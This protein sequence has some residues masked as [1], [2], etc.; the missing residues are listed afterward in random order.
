MTE[1]MCLLFVSGTVDKLMAGTII[2]SG[3][4][5][6]DME[7]DVFVSFWGLMEFR[8]GAP[9]NTKVSYEGK[10]M[11]A[12]I[13]QIMREKKVQ[14]WIEMLR[15]A[16]EVGNVKVYACAMFSD[17]L[18]LQKSDYDPI[19]DEIIGV[20]EFVSMAKDAKMTLFI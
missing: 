17:L 5:A 20:A 18:G 12:E 10:D 15:Q 14:P 4:V 13:F 8:K 9:V 6:N 7:V 1:K 16:K 3:G 19:V 11:A 2:A